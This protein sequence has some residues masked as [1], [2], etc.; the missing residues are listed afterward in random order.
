VK[1]S[2]REKRRGR[3]GENWLRLHINDSIEIFISTSTL[4]GWGDGGFPT[5]GK[6]G[7]SLEG[8][9]QRGKRAGSNL[10]VV[11]GS[12]GKGPI[13]ISILLDCFLPRGS[14]GVEKGG[15]VRAFHS[16]TVG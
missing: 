3:R 1:R 15:M 12:W 16:D 7:T 8:G 4:Y 11:S 9:G 14:P 5:G 13:F 6:E 2:H 10:I